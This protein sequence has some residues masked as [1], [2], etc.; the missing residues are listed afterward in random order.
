MLTNSAPPMNFISTFDGSHLDYPRPFKHARKSDL[1]KDFLNF[2]Y[3]DNEGG[4]K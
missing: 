1:V 4:Y 2:P 3:S